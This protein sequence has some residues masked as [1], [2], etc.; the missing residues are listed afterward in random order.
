M[1]LFNGYVIWVFHIYDLMDFC[2]LGYCKYC[3][4]EHLYTSIFIFLNI[5]TLVGLVTNTLSVLLQMLHYTLHHQN[6]IFK[7]S[8][9]CHS[10]LKNLSQLAYG[11]FYLLKFKIKL[12]ISVERL[13]NFQRDSIGF[14]KLIWAGYPFFNNIKFSN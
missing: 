4:C 10:T 11:K 8:Q 5:H 14:F 7:I 13:L 3:C 12:L 9:C 2:T 1:I 6:I